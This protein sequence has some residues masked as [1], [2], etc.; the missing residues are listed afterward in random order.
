M[1]VD[2]V[3]LFNEEVPAALAAKAADARKIGGKY[4]LNVT[5]S[6]AWTIDLTADPPT[7]TAA[8]WMEMG[9]RSPGPR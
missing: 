5:G 1:A 7:C 2:T 4:Q 9:G 6:G 3:K 8:P